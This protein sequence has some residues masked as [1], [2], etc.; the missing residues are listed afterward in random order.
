MP[1]YIIQRNKKKFEQLYFKLDLRLY[2]YDKPLGIAEKLSYISPKS[3][4]INE[5]KPNF[6]QK[7]A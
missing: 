4:Q 6:S 1:F 5:I 3:H 2:L 7:Y